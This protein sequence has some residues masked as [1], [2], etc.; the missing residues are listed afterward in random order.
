[1][2]PAGD[3]DIRRLDVAMH[4]ARRVR[5]IQGIGD[6]NGQRQ[7]GFQFQRFLRHALPQRHSLHELHGD[8]DVAVLLADFVNCADVGMVEHR[9][10][11]RLAPEPRHAFG[12]AGQV[13]A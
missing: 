3:E 11:A 13:R 6:F 9:Q 2:S 5:G 7:R 12:V 4:D 1:M 8:E 10:R